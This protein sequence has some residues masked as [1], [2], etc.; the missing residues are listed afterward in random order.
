MTV[1]GDNKEKGTIDNTKSLKITFSRHPTEE[2][3]G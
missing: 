2:A 1:L 3:G